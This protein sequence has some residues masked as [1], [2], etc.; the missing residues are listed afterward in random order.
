MC[1]TFPGKDQITMINVGDLIALP[2]P[3]SRH[4]WM[5]CW[6]ELVVQSH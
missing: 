3:P 2:P 6:R 4:L 5:S 1:Y